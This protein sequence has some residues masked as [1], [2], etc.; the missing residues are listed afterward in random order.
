MAYGDFVPILS[1]NPCFC[2]DDPTT[3]G[4]KHYE[5]K[6]IVMPVP[7]VGIKLTPSEL[8]KTARRIEELEKR[9]SEL[10]RAED[11]RE[12]YQLEQNERS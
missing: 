9:V 12:T 10:E 8:I 4:H 6:R 3:G 1:R 2:G 11:A 5:A 7:D